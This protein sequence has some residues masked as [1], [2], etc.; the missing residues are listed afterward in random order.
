MLLT[1]ELSLQPQTLPSRTWQDK[2]AKVFLGNCT[3][4]SHGS[5]PVAPG[6]TP[7]TGLTVLQGTSPPLLYQFPVT[8][9]SHSVLPHRHAPGRPTKAVHRSHCP[10]EEFQAKEPH[11]TSSVTGSSGATASVDSVYSFLFFLTEIAFSDYT[12]VIL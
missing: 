9:L 6:G 11:R 4:Q 7:D 8:S 2:Q 12:E 3:H 10:E 5:G 1:A